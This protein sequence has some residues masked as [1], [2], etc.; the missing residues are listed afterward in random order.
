MVAFCQWESDTW[1]MNFEGKSRIFD[2]FGLGNSR[3]RADA[4][5]QLVRDGIWIIPDRCGPNWPK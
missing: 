5:W 4:T 3:V 2:F 1:H